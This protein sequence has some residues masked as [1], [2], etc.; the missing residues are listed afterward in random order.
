V[1]QLLRESPLDGD[2]RELVEVIRTSG[3]SLLAILDGVLDL[4]KLEAGKMAIERAPVDVRGATH[5]VA[6][7]FQARAAS[8]GVS[9]LTDVA[10]DVPTSIIGDPVRIRQVLLNLVGNAVKFTDQ[11]SVTIRVRLGSQ[12]PG[13]NGGARVQF[14]VLDTGVGVSPE[15][16]RMLFDDFVQADSSST[17][18]HSGTGLGLAIVRRLAESMKAKVIAES[19]LGVGSC[20]GLDLPLEIAGVE[21]LPEAGPLTEAS[22]VSTATDKAAPSGIGLRVLVAEDNAVN[23]LV[24]KR[25]LEKLGCKVATAHDGHEAIEMVAR[26]PFDV[27]LMDCHMP[28]LD[29]YE[30]TRNLRA[31]G[32]Q[33]QTLP[34]IAL[35][36]STTPEDRAKCREAGMDDFLSKPLLLETL[37]KTLEQVQGAG[38]TTSSRV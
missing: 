5:Q 26:Y 32:G 29:G 17:R 1:A 37:R 7:L 34:I 9:I 8:K 15:D 13:E 21:G 16:L 10:A 6:E 27:I 3:E 4:A 38:V 35:T 33:F 11:G 19:Q 18:R 25:M 23:R 14:L 12:Q 20:F 30:V 2:Q 22:E 31:R 24:A 28:G 36:A